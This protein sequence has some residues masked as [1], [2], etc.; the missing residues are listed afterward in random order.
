MSDQARDQHDCGADA[1]AYVLD[2][3][4]PAEAD[5]FCRHLYTCA[6]CQDEVDGFK[7]VV[8]T[9]L[10]AC[11]STAPKDLRHRV[12]REID[13]EDLTARAARRASWRLQS[14]FAGVCAAVLIAVAGLAGS[15]L[16]GSSGPGGT[17][18]YAAWLGDAMVKVCGQSAEL[19]VGRL[20]QPGAG[21][22]YQVW[23]KHGSHPSQ[24]TKALFDVD[25]SGRSDVLV[26]GSVRG[27]STV[28]VTVEP[29]G[30]TRVPTSAP[31]IIA[32]LA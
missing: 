6:V 26:P 30:G 3:L 2:A 14:A 27:V 15:Q 32:S 28:V 1:A 8:S 23:F 4:K 17:H 18:V 22:I 21:K 19:I 29:S 9:L 11:P 5:A 31:V 7:G 25:T 10:A 20:P 13:A 12:I 16:G 24:P